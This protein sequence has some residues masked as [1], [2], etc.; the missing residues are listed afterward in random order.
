MPPHPSDAVT[1]VISGIGTAALQPGTA[2]GAGHEIV[3]G[4]IS[5]VLVMVWTHEAVLPLT[6]VA[7]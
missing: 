2:M 3:G 4:V 7:I 5:T 1:L 6:S